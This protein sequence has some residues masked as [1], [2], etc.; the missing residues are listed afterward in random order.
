MN[1]G[2]EIDVELDYRHDPSD[3]CDGK[4]GRYAC[5][6]VECSARLCSCESAYGHDCE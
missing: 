5:R 2:Q 3:F 4:P 6:C 1:I